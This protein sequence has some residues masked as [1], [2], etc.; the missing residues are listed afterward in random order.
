MDQ[1]N[2]YSKALKRKTD[3]NDGTWGFDNKHHYTTFLW[4]MVYL[5]S[6]PKGLF[7][8]QKTRYKYKIHQVCMDE[9]AQFTSYQK[10]KK[11]SASF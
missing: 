4:S 7:H 8:L 5:G 2:D 10:K 1:V 3:L 6:F 9:N 11:K